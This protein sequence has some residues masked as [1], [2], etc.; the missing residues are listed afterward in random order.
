[1]TKAIYELW[2]YD[3]GNLRDAYDTEQAALKEARSTI[4]IDGRDAVAT[5]ALL[6]DDTKSPAKTVVATGAELA[7]YA[8]GMQLRAV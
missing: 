5:W 3:T 7:A 1:M 6:R 2:D 4:Q 8:A